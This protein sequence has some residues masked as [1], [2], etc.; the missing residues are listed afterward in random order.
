MVSHHL[1]CIHHENVYKKKALT[2]EGGVPLSLFYNQHLDR[3]K[4]KA[5]GWGDVVSPCLFLI[6]GIGAEAD[7]QGEGQG[8]EGRRFGWNGV[9]PPTGE[10]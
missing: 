5:G 3:H 1:L 7:G 10:F 2:R 6:S 4:K 8:E 9:E